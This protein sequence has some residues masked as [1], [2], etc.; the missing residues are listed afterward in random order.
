MRV[1]GTP[2]ATPRRWFATLLVA[3]LC[4]GL[5][6]ASVLAAAPTATDDTFTV[7]VN[8]GPTSLDVLANDTD[9]DAGDDLTIT[10]VGDP[11]NGTAAIDGDVVTYQ[12]DA[13]FHGID[14]FDYTIEDSTAGTS[15]ATVTVIVNSP[16]VAV[17]DPGT[18]CGPTSNFGGGVPVQRGLSD[19][20]PA[21]RM[22]PKTTSRSLAPVHAH[23]QRH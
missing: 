2:A 6:P 9:S 5:L 15:D 17:D 1:A 14:T 7:P 21:S 12:P 16:P 23:L 3:T 13:D 18:A 22:I 11:P 20:R 19:C 10:I 4:A 8:A